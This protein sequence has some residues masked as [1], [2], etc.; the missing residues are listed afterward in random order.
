MGQLHVEGICL[1]PELVSTC[2][3]SELKKALQNMEQTICGKIMGRRE[4]E[5]H[6]TDMHEVRKNIHI[7]EIKDS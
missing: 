3:M 4:Q 6:K 7:D 1:S 5:S 2:T